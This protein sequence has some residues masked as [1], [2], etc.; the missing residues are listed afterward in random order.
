M[1]RLPWT[2][3]RNNNSNTSPHCPRPRRVEPTA[4]TVGVNS[5]SVF[6]ALPRAGEAGGEGPAATVPGGRRWPGKIFAPTNE[7][8]ERDLDPKLC[9]FLLKPRN[10]RSL[11]RFLFHVLLSRLHSASGAWPAASAS[12]TTRMTLSGEHLESPQTR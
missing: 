4:T 7:A 11:Q 8:L 12:S 1:Q 2:C 6:L 9:A 3:C 5:K 10:L